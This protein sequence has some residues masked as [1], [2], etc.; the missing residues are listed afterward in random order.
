M[1]PR[2]ELA[3]V[4]YSKEPAL[5]AV[6]FATDSS[7]YHSKSQLMETLTVSDVCFKSFYHS[8]FYFVCFVYGTVRCCQTL[9]EANWKFQICR[10]SSALSGSISKRN[11]A[12][13]PAPGNLR[14]Q[15]C[16]RR[17]KLNACLCVCVQSICHSLLAS[18]ILKVRCCFF[19][20]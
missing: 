1:A 19:Y 20:P 5:R 3:H 16:S 12:L 2:K 9:Y 8:F 15:T 11:P 13:T 7:P 6:S 17:R 4:I 18:Q 10:H 14:L